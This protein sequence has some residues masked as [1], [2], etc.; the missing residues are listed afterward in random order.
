MKTIQRPSIFTQSPESLGYAFLASTG[1]GT[2]PAANDAIFIPVKLERPALVKR[3]FALNGNSLNG[4]IDMGIYTKDGA[5]IVSIGS[6]AQAG[7][8]AIQFFDITDTFLT[9][10]LYY[11]AVAMNNN[12]ATLRRFNITAIRQQQFGILRAASAFPLPS[13]VTFTSVNAAFVPNIGM[14]LTGLS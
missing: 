14:E 5:R 8:V 13:S 12:S 4:N 7:V 9:P 10:N 6:T 3:L 1:N 11:M 2:Y